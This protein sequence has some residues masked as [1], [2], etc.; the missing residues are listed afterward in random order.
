MNTP[1]GRYRFTRL[2]YGIHSAQEVFHK[3]ISENFMHIKGVETDIDDFLIWGK[4][5][6]EHNRS[7]IK[8][9]ERAKK[10]G[11][12]MNLDKCKFKADDLIYIGHKISARGIQPDESKVKAITEMPEPTDKKGVQRILGMVNYVAKFLPKL[13][14]ATSPLRE[15]LHKDVHWHWDEHHR[16]A[17]NEVKKLLSSETCLAFFENPSP[18]KLI[19]VNL[20]CL[21]HY[22]KKKGQFHIYQDLSQVQSRIMQ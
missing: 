1:F 22:F 20:V 12:T 8:C 2:P 21:Q 19:L 15:L 17:F 6:K 13:S 4:N 9:L 7:V 18:F 11:L 3:R 10:I 14:E 5:E 16:K